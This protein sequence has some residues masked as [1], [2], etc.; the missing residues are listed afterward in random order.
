MEMNVQIV[1]SSE[2][3]HR[4]VLQVCTNVSTVNPK[5]ETVCA[6]KILITVY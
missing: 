5:M 6:S 3:L 1:W 2:M 4:I